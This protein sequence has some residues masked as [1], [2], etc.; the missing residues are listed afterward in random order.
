V[1]GRTVVASM[2]LIPRAAALDEYQ[3]RPGSLNALD[4]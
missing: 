2:G 4:S 1:A 3:Q